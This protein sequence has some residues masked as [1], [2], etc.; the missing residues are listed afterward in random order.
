ML[1]DLKDLQVG[2]EIIRGV[3]SG[4][5]EYNKVLAM[6]DKTRTRIK[7]SRY[8]F[9]PPGVTYSY[10]KANTNVSEHNE[11]LYITLYGNAWLVKREGGIYG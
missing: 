8:K 6:P 9:T 7:L 3:G 4:R 1:I 5:L 10:Y 11:C 2:D